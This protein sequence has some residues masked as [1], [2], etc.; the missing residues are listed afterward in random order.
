MKVWVI[1]GKSGIG[2]AIANKCRANGDETFV[3]GIADVDV[4]SD[5]AITGYFVT[6][7]GF[8]AVVYSAGVNELSWIKDLKPESAQETFNV[9]VIGF[10]R[11]LKTV[12]AWGDAVNPR[13]PCSNVVAVSSDAAT[14]PM[15]TSIAY[16]ASKAAL[17]MAV[18]VAAR[19]LAP[20]V[21]VNAVSPGMIDGT[22]M[23]AYIDNTVPKIRNW[24]PT[25][26]ATY[27]MSQSPIGR[28]GDAKEIADVVFDVLYGP[29]F[30]TGSIITV[31]GGR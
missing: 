7:G 11:L 16:C 9:N 26:A 18:K 30:L 5:G 12:A 14:R 22:A 13:R 28:R 21:R 24:T 27:E 6:Q 19:E 25:E 10:M 8:D 4:R 20:A 15:R 17:D 1:G 23:T 29:D 2:K 3:T 31:N